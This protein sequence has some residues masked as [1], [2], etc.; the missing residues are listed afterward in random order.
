MPKRP[1]GFYADQQPEFTE[2][3]LPLQHY[4]TYGGTVQYQQL[5][6]EGKRKQKASVYLPKFLFPEGHG[7]PDEVQITVSVP[8]RAKWTKSR[9]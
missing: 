9:G 2:R 7:F 4:A 5:V 3:T 6:V 8:E 1:I